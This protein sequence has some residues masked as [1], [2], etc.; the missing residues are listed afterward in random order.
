MGIQGTDAADGL[1]RF[2][3]RVGN[4]KSLRRTGW[5]DRGVPP[6]DAESVADHTF[7]TALL[8]WLA[9]P[10]GELDRDRVLKMALIHDLA[11]SLVGDEPPYDPAELSAISDGDRTS[12]LNRRHT[13]NE[14]RS[15]AKIAAESEAFA[16]LI[17]DLPGELAD[18][19]Q[20][21]WGD[22]EAGTTPEALFV[23]QSDKLETFLQS[24]E[25]L[26]ADPTRPMESFAAEVSAVIDIPALQRLR[27]E[28]AALEI[29][30]GGNGGVTMVE[31]NA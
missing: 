3:H 26:A 8:T 21:L 27:D 23:K 24:R 5:L 4:L 9:A 29:E 16:E 6:E 7:R 14:A 22:L 13:R 30:P 10:E 2:L 12:F 28:L 31:E 15:T 11:E 18:E 20:E 17:A 1:A 19:L 25:Y